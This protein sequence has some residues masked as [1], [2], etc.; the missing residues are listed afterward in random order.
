M[1]LNAHLALTKGAETLASVR[2][3]WTAV[4]AVVATAEVRR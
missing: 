1:D 4:G 2:N 3:R